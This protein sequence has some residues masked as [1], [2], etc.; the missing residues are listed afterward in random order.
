MILRSSAQLSG[1]DKK[2]LAQLSGADKKTPTQLSGAEKSVP[3]AKVPP[4][5]IFAVVGAT[6]RPTQPV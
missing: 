1:A 5:A 6:Q 4:T 2:T 3:V